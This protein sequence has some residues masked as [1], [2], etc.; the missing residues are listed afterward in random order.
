MHEYF[1]S[2]SLR[3]RRIINSGKMRIPEKDF[4]II[5]DLIMHKLSINGYKNK[6]PKYINDTFKIFCLNKKEIVFDAFFIGDNYLNNP[7][8]NDLIINSKNNLFSNNIFKLFSNLK[9]I[10]I[11][12]SHWKLRQQLPFQDNVKSRSEN[13]DYWKD[14]YGLRFD[15]FFQNIAPINY[16][17][18]L[19]SLLHLISKYKRNKKY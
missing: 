11:Q 1:Y 19:L 2:F 14:Q 15:N 4:K 18:D 10:I 12:K 13:W 17:F 7:I 5:R 9:S 6:F 8:L 16:S 3:L